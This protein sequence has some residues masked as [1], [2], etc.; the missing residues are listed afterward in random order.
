MKTWRVAIAAGGT[1]GHVYPALAV[2]HAFQQLPE[3]VEP[4]FIGTADG[5]EARIVPPSGYRFHTVPAA[6]LFGVGVAGK[7]RAMRTLYAGI[8]QARR[9]LKASG[10]Q[11]VLGLGGYVSA[12]AVLAAWGLGLRTALHEANVEPGLANKLLAHVV[13]RVYLGFEAARR[14]FPKAKNVVTGNPVRP[15]VATVTLPRLLPNGKRPFHVLI[16]GG[17]QGSRFFNENGP[18]LLWHLANDGF[19]LEVRHQT[20]GFDLEAVRQRYARAGISAAVVPYID[21]MADA[22]GWADFAIAR[23]GA[24]TIAELAVSGLPALLVPLPAA[25]GD[26]QTG[27]AIAL[28]EAGGGWW[29]HERDWRADQLAQRIAD[30][31]RDTSA[32]QAVSHAV[33]RF[34]RPNAARTLVADCLQLMSAG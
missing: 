30:L 15:D 11:M 10:T 27:N 14:A 2:A 4:L 21:G 20:G 12:P 26:H 7:V 19:R 24:A 8:A 22:Y 23:C 31:L 17:S 6:P 3:P 16:T 33:Q 5:F 1:A 25:S 34:A 9:L 28:A 18:D 13:D 32:W 29:V